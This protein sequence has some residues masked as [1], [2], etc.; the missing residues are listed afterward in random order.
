M[1]T[2]KTIERFLTET[3]CEDIIKYSISN[4][5]LHSGKVKGQGKNENVRKSNVAHINYDNQFP[6]FSTRLK[7]LIT[8]MFDLKGVEIDNTFENTFQFTE[9]SQGDFYDWHTDSINH[10]IELS[11]K[12]YCSIVIQLNNEYEGGDLEMKPFNEV[13]NIMVFKRGIGNLFIFLSDIEHRVSPVTTGVRH[14]IV[15]WFY[16]KNTNGYK[17]TII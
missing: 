5:E 16:L 6:G 8:P 12:R 13:E 10:D 15:G 1:F 11:N 9:Y 3:E 17:K 7:N 2:F 4:Y 14:S